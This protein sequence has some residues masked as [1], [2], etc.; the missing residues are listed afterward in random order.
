[1]V[2]GQQV[3]TSL[4]CVQL[5]S[6]DCACRRVFERQEPDECSLRFCDGSFIQA[7]YFQL[8]ASASVPV[9]VS[10]EHTVWPF[11]GTMFV[12][13]RDDTYSA[14]IVAARLGYVF[15]LASLSCSVHCFRS[16]DVVRALLRAASTSSAIYSAVV[17]SAVM[18]STFVGQC[19]SAFAFLVLA[20][21]ARAL[22][23]PTTLS[24]SFR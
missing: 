20:I 24:I 15:T 14:G 9:Q 22:L 19:I 2:D 16:S 3:A 12:P 1:M 17:L 4:G 23:L 7:M 11:D 13:V 18:R 6:I 21:R 5:L 8:Y 10:M